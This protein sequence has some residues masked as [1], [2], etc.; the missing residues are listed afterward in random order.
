MQVTACEADNTRNCFTRMKAPATCGELVQGAIDGQDWLVNCPIDLFAS[1]TVYA[2]ATPGL[3]LS[4]PQQ[5]HKI[6]DAVRLLA[7]ACR[8][9]L[10]Y[11]VTVASDIPRSKG[12][13]S[14]TADIS[15]ALAA[16]CHSAHISLPA[17]VFARLLAEVEPSD[18]IHFPGIAHVNHLTGELFA[19]MPPPRDLQVLAVDCGGEVETLQFDRERARSIY[20]QHRTRIASALAL[21]KRGLYAPN[22]LWV[23]AAATESAALSQLIHD[24]PQFHDLVAIAREVG[25][26]G[27]NCAHSG[28][29]LGV[30]YRAG[31][32]LE[33]RLVAR[34]E[35]T[36]G[37]DVAIVGNFNIIGG[38]C[39]AY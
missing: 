39:F 34:I 29:I 30:L 38:G 23:A 37:T 16:I 6:Y 11:R 33:E 12:M 36:F 19:L 24:K 31:V 28:S 1:A 32:R 21:L 20:K 5:F 18:C 3:Y 14:S 25:A 22:P 15:A 8:L 7:Q 27:V 2:S 4:N 13:A 26:L 17:D 35:R 9:E 10:H